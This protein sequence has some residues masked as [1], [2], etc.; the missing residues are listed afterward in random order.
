MNQPGTQTIVNGQG[1]VSFQSAQVPADAQ[2]LINEIFALRFTDANPKDLGIPPVDTITPQTFIVKLTDGT[3]LRPP[4]PIF[5]TLVVLEAPSGPAPNGGKIRFHL[6]IPPELVASGNRFTERPGTGNTVLDTVC[7][8]YRFADINP[9]DLPTVTA[10]FSSFVYR[11]AQQTIVTSS[12]TLEQ[13]AAITAAQVPLS[14]I[15]DDDNTN[16]GEATWTYSVRT[17]RSTSSPP[18]RR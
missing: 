18:A 1:I 15:P 12:L 16:I 2:R 7:G 11:D 8:T 17:R 5:I 9:E 10:R 3:R 4:L 14:V 13:L 6:D